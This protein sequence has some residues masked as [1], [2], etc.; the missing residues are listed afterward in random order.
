MIYLITIGYLVC[1][2]IV[3]GVLF[4]DIEGSYPSKTQH[5]YHDSM[6]TSIL[7]S[8]ALG[9]LGPIGILLAVLTTG[10]ARFG[11]KYK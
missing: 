2:V 11:I 6:S 1:A 9:A 7:F 5:E 8:L 3:Y 4:A 10:F